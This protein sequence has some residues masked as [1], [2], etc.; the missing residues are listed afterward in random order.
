MEHKSRILLVDD[1]DK[2]LN[3]FQRNLRKEYDISIASSGSQAIE[4]IKQEQEFAVIVSDMKM[5]EMNG[6]EFLLQAK[7]LSPNSIRVML[8]G[9]NDQETVKTALNQCD[10]YQFLAK[11]CTKEEYIEAINASIKHYKLVIAEKE[12]L[13]KTLKCSLE[14][15]TDIL[16]MNNPKEFGHAKR[17]TELTLK[18][19]EKLQLPN[20]WELET[21]AMLSQ[22][23]VLLLPEELIEKH[24]LHHAKTD[25]EI[26]MFHQHPLIAA[27][28]INKIPRL[29]G[30]SN[31]IRFQEKGYDGSGYPRMK[32]QG[33]NIPLGAR[34][35]KLAIDFDKYRNTGLTPL[36]AID[37]LLSMKQLYDPKL[38]H[39]LIEIVQNT[40]KTR[41]IY[42]SVEKLVSGQ[43]LAEDIRTKEN[44][45]V[46]TKGEIITQVVIAKLKNYIK[47]N[48]IKNEIS[49]V[50]T[51]VE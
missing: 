49:V 28:L 8:T 27:D 25:E 24:C 2:L 47:N 20:Q 40:I 9:N 44:T 22:L 46:I 23:G 48:M 7:A 32:L 4:L 19:A 15:L 26:A 1:E 16:A 6:V 5:P 50:M 31:N 11:P 39:A 37:Q 3:A 51:L 21:S 13:E 18:L 14:I 36:L 45:L 10:I 17:L 43:V 33:N 29:E 38:L 42:L 41:V 30:V 34:I 35:L 12:I